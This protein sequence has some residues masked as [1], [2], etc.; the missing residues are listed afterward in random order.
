MGSETGL[1]PFWKL[2]E[3]SAGDSIP[4]LILENT[5][6]QSTWSVLGFG[7]IQLSIDDSMLKCLRTMGNTH[8]VTVTNSAV[9]QLMLYN[10]MNTTYNFN[11]TTMTN[12]NTYV[13]PNSVTIN[14][15]ITFTQDAQIQNWFSP[16]EITRTYEV[17][18]K[19]GDGPAQGASL[20]LYATGDTLVW[21]GTTDVEG[22]VNF[23]LNFTDSNYMNS[24][25]LEADYPGNII[26]QK[27]VRLLT[28][29][30]IEIL[31]YDATLSVTEGTI[32]TEIAITG[33]GF[34]DKKGKVLINGTAAKIAKGG[35]GPDQITCTIS[36]P[37]LPVNVAHPVSVVVDKVPRTLDDTFT[38]RL[39]AL[40]DL[41]VTSGAYLDPPIR[42]TGRF[43]GAK[44]GKAYL[45][46]PATEK[47]KTLKVTDWR[48]NESTG[49]SELTFV[50][51]KPSKSLPAGTYQLQISNKVGQATTT[52]E[53]TV[54]V[55]PPT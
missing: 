52:P 55:P 47:K 2:S 6:I 31:F 10:S 21:S 24:W 36:K 1:H 4:E 54:L 14:G 30:P 38:I 35:W 49:I 27:E 20:S 25:R 13:P 5:E 51:P 44:K 11:N 29:T 42:V 37:P 32:G 53:F 41:S 15:N 3:H 22:K 18:V 33:S 7:G 40:D 45:Y 34:G 19:D 50:V 46:N 8:D 28:S 39:P 26:S 48:M 9:D 12:L 23:T 16:S 43:F 17:L